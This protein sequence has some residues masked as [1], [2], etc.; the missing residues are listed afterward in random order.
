MQSV[1]CRC[2]CVYPIKR[3]PLVLK[4]PL[5]LTLQ[6]LFTNKVI[7]SVGPRHVCS[8]YHGSEMS[9]MVFLLT[10]SSLKYHRSPKLSHEEHNSSRTCVVQSL[11]CICIM[12]TD[13]ALTIKSVW[14]RGGIAHLENYTPQRSA[15]SRYSLQAT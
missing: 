5:Q 7:S 12:E 13:L 8:E 3:H 4:A 2:G 15:F 10:N 1:L 9:D 11:S 6:Q 14:N